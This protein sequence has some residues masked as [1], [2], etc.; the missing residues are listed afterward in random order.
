MKRRNRNLIALTLLA[1]LALQIL[2]SLAGCSG[3]E[4][5]KNLPTFEGIPTFVV[6][7]ASDYV[8]GEFEKSQKSLAADDGYKLLDW[9]LDK[10][11]YCTKYDDFEGMTLD[12]Y[13]LKY[14][15]K[16]DNIDKVPLVGDA[17]ATE[18]GW[19]CPGAGDSTY[20]IFEGAQYICA[21]CCP[22]G[23]PANTA[24][25]NI[26]RDDLQGALAA[27]GVSASN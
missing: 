8:K 20:L 14:T 21:L 25:N 19:Y 17:H 10:V 11:T 5:S 6:E 23:D 12:I 13:S 2:T 4:K 16:A 27:S 26:F 3:S 1:L 9:K 7:S 18:N 15:Y 22:D 24:E